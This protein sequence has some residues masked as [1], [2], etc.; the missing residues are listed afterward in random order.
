MVR[1]FRIIKKSLNLKDDQ[2]QTRF[3]EAMYVKVII[4]QLIHINFKLILI[5][6]KGTIG[7]FK[8]NLTIPS[9]FQCEHCVFQ[10]NF[11]LK[12]NENSTEMFANCFTFQFLK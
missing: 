2:G 4:F 12:L 8:Y 3:E 10:V 11:D 9:D 6:R 1:E 7:H 5:F